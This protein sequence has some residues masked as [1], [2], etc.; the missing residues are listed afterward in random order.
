MA[1]CSLATSPKLINNSFSILFSLVVV[2][3][4]VVHIHIQMKAFAIRSIILTMMPMHPSIPSPSIAL[5]L[6]SH[7]FSSLPA[8]SSGSR[9]SRP[10]DYFFEK[11][12]EIAHVTSNITIPGAAVRGRGLVQLWPMRR[13][14]EREKEREMATV[15]HCFIHHGAPSTTK[16]NNLKLFLKY[17][18]TLTYSEHEPIWC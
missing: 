3:T 5:V 14:R 8:E 2:N 12:I 9:V 16:E 6:A 10:S 1:P 4:T 11:R 15:R 7:L 17:P 18:R 13:Q